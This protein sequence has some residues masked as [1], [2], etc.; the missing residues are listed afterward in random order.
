MYHQFH[1]LFVAHSTQ[2]PISICPNMANRHGLITGATGTGKSV[3]LQVLAE[4]FSQAGIPCFLADIKGDLSGISLPGQLSPFIQNRMALFG[5]DK[6]DFQACPVCFYDLF[7]EQGHPIRATVSQ[8][9]PQLISRLL[10]LNATQDGVLNIIFR[11]ADDQ[12]LLI[13]DLKDLRAM[14]DFVSNNAKRFSPLY[15]NISPASVGAIQRALLQLENQGA[16]L[17][18]GEPSFDINDLIQSRDGKGIIS[19]LAADKLMLNPKLYSTFMLWLLS[20]L[21]ASFPEVGDLDKPKLVFFFDEAHL[22][23]QDAPK[24][25]VEKIEQ[26]I[27][28]IRSKG[29]GIFFISQLPTDIP[30]SILAQLGNRI[31]HALRAFTPRDLKAVKVAAQTFRPNPLFRTE[32]AI[33][34]LETGEALVSFLDR[35]GAPSIVQRAKMLFPLSQIGAISPNQRGQLIGLSPI[36][37]KYD[38]LVDRESAYEMLLQIAEKDLAEKES[39]KAEKVSQK[40]SKDKPAGTASRQPKPKPGILSK[41]SKAVLTALTATIGSL[42]G[43]AVSNKVTGKKSKSK[44]SATQKIVK[45]ATSA[46]TRTMTRE[47]SRSILGN[48]AKH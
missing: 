30:D 38:S 26:V 16:N 11:I 1:G 4:S 44:S 45:N 31:Q 35:N 13:L 23:F 19:L 3:S 32:E 2:G 42:V 41:V 5:L 12:G 24:P 20:E 34:S 47:I 14:L 6:V 10:A 9:G 21:Y 25:L 22:L 7:A 43:T 39:Q 46:A 15:G 18:F 29:V 37:H 8:M 36:G 27:R 33:S 48:L 28:L 40:A 17:F